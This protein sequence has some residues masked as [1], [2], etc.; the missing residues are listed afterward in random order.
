MK[1]VYLVLENHIEKRNV[2][3]LYKIFNSTFL[4][5][6]CK[7]ANAIIPN[8]IN[9]ILEEFT[10]PEFLK[11]L[12]YLK[13]KYPK[14]KYVCIFSEYITKNTFNNFKLK[15]NINFKYYLIK[16]LE[17]LIKK[18]HKLI[19]KIEKKIFIQKTDIYRKVYKF[20]VLF[21]RRLLIRFFDK[22]I[23]ED[24]YMK[25]RFLTFVKASKYIDFFLSWNEKQKKKLNQFTNKKVLI[26][27][28]DLKKVSANPVKGISIS[29]TA[30]KYRIEI[31]KK[32]L[33]KIQ[34]KN[35]F[36]HFIKNY[37][38]IKKNFY[39]YSLNPGKEKIW[40]YPSLIRYLISLERNEIPLVIENYKDKM[41][42]WLTFKI[43]L[44]SITNKNFFS[45]K[46]YNKKLRIINKK[47]SILNKIKIK[48]IRKI[49][50]HFDE[51]KR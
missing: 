8:N 49:K 27:Y 40:P 36:H 18:I 15:Q 21:F 31:I 46:N 32:I 5:I 3:D 30:T 47:I 35:N 25:E 24:I 7:I 33:H 48:Q 2:K 39:W 20:F 44:K 34:V 23:I 41:T 45:K 51:L 29:G 17:N 26:L 6:E 43:K 16:F 12:I 22:D 28:P 1:V 42:S 14:T 38:L 37:F 9:I 50:K 10:N 13:K 4:K 19:V 11:K